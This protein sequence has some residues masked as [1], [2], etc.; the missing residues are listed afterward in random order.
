M[1][2]TLIASLACLRSS[3][4]QWNFT[5]S[6]FKQ[7]KCVQ[8]FWFK[9]CGLCQFYICAQVQNVFHFW[10]QHV[11][12]GCVWYIYFFKNIHEEHVCLSYLKWRVYSRGHSKSIYE[13]IYIY[14]MYIN[15]RFRNCLNKKK[16]WYFHW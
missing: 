15:L 4:E 10:P 8:S 9:S 11:S 6:Y 5:V 13:I 16:S 12:S 2:S 14:Y 1:P 7:L 3:S